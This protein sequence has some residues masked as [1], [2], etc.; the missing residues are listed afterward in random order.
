[1][2]MHFS[3]SHY[4]QK[5]HSAHDVP[6]HIGNEHT[7]KEK[8]E[9]GFLQNKSKLLNI[10]TKGVLPLVCLDEFGNYEHLPL[11][12]ANSLVRLRENLVMTVLV[13]A[14]PTMKRQFCFQ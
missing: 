6:I 5:L 8:Y 13:M 7:Q 9:L 4:H 10:W 12:R 3:T 11:R 2:I 1:M 14:N